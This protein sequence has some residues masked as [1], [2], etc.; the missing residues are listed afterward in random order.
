MKKKEK[1]GGV[2]EPTEN[3]IRPCSAGKSISSKDDLRVRELRRGQRATQ[4]PH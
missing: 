1:N 3:S 2:F 4:R